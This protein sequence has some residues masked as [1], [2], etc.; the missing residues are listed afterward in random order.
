MI[1]SRA[2]SVAL[3]N[4]AEATKMIKSDTG[5]RKLKPHAHSTFTLR[6]L[7]PRLHDFYASYAELELQLSAVQNDIDFLA[8][9]L[10]ASIMITDAPQ[11]NVHYEPL[12]KTDLSPVCSPN[13]YQNHREQISNG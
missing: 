7:F 4:I 10:H 5:M 3:D 6:W 11:G 2:L 9:D 8:S 12:L 1:Y 13:D